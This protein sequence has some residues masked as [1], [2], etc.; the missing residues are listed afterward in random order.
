MKASFCVIASCLVVFALK[1][2]A[3]DTG[4]EDDFDYGNTGCP[5]PVLGNYKS[6]MTK[7][8]GCKNKC[9]S[10]YEVLN[11]TTPCYV[12]DQKV[13]NNMVPLR[14]YSKCPLGFCENGECKPNDQAEDCYKG[15]EE[16]K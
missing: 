7:P 1:G 8:V 2:T 12:I 13:F 6:N 10:G 15:R 14:Q 11:D 9:G 4:T 3:E 5:F 16:Q